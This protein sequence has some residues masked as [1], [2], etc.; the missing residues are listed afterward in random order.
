MTPIIE[1]RPHG[2]GA[3]LMSGRQLLSAWKLSYPNTCEM[4]GADC[5]GTWARAGYVHRIQCSISAEANAEPC[6]CPTAP[7]T[8]TCRFLELPL[9]ARLFQVFP[10]NLTHFDCFHHD[11]AKVGHQRCRKVTFTAIRDPVGCSEL[12]VQHSPAQAMHHKRPNTIT[13]LWDEEYMP[14]L[15]ASSTPALL[16]SMGW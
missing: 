2:L 4:K 10:I 13:P 15:T 14:Q 12:V 1:V 8:H 6:P 16:S 7:T 3:S 9:R 5:S 11:L